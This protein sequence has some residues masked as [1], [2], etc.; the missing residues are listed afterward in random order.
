M[1]RPRFV[2][3]FGW[4]GDGGLGDKLIQQ[5]QHGIKTATACPKLLYTPQELKEL[6]ASVGKIVTVVDKRDQ[7]RCQIKQLEV[8][9][10]TFGDPDLRLVKGEGCSE[11]SQWRRKHRHVWD[12]LFDKA[13]AQLDNDTVLVVELFMRWPPIAGHN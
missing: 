5:I 13:G 11:P 2:S 12:D 10:T 8:F 3:K 7:P 6:H 9:E 1:K 4:E